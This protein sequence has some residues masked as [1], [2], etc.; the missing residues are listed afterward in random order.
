[1]HL[2]PVARLHSSCIAGTLF[3]LLHFGIEAFHVDRHPM[4]AQDQLGQVERKPKGVVKLKSHFATQHAPLF[5]GHIFF[6]QPDTGLQGTQ[7]RFFLLFHHFPNKS[8][9]GNQLRVCLSHHVDQ[10]GNKPVHERFVHIQEGI[11]V[12]N[13]AT[14]DTTNHISRFGVRRQL[15]VGNGKSDCAQMVRNDPHGDVFFIVLTIGGVANLSDCADDGLK[16]VGVVVRQL[17]LHCHAE[18]LKAHAGINYFCR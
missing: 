2:C 8:L 7:E 12:A 11:S 14:Q 10:C 16:Q 4:L 13:G 3:L 1:M 17:P 9:L 6:Q 5:L 15:T 18:T